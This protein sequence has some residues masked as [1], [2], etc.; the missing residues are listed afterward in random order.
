MK[1]VRHNA[2]RKN[3]ERN[4]HLRLLHHAHEGVIVFA[5]IEQPRP[6]H[7]AIE[8]VED[9]PGSPTSRPIWHGAG[10]IKFLARLGKRPRVPFYGFCKMEPEV[11]HAT[12][13][14]LFPAPVAMTTN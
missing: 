13:A 6:A 10:L 7:G 5:L 4:S 12:S 3:P 9:K 8:D 2:V 14:A 1:M 11:F